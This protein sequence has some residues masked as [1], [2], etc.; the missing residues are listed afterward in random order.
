MRVSSRWYWFL[1]A[2]IFFL[3]FVFPLHASTINPGFE[4]GDLA[5]WDSNGNVS[6]ISSANLPSGWQD[7]DEFG[8]PIN[9][10]GGDFGYFIYDNSTDVSPHEGNYMASIGSFTATENWADGNLLSQTLTGTYNNPELTLSYNMW[11]YDYDPFDSFSIGVGNEVV[12]SV[13]ASFVGGGSRAPNI[14]YVWLEYSNHR[15]DTSTGRYCKRFY[16]LDFSG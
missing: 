11:S 16:N 6:V 10:P 7:T 14:G 9:T 12:W 4:Y 13:G 15:F 3:F 1:L 8:N 5:G 2:I